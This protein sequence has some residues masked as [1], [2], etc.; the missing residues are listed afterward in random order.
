MAQ[1]VEGTSDGGE[2]EFV[3][4]MKDNGLKK[5]DTI[6]KILNAFNSVY[7]PLSG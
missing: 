7:V 5:Q 1:Q 3:S 2:N 4:W 6:N